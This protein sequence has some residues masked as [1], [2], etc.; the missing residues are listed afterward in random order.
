LRDVGEGSSRPPQRLTGPPGT[1]NGFESSARIGLLGSDI[2]S[3]ASF[4]KA[5]GG[6]PPPV[7]ADLTAETGA[8]PVILRA[9]DFGGSL[10]GS[11]V[12]DESPVFP[13]APVASISVGRVPE[14]P[15]SCAARR[16]RS[17]AMLNHYR[18]NVFS[19]RSRNPLR[20][21]RGVSLDLPSPP[22]LA[23]GPSPW[24][25]RFPPRMRG[26]KTAWVNRQSLPRIVTASSSVPVS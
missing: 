15:I 13:S 20:D 26:G 21:E 8:R 24:S 2:P 4:S 10:P 23:A 7:L 25:A 19:G 12:A 18:L 22:A 5:V 11:L 6:A 1:G 17:S 16:W 9:K 14:T 3:F